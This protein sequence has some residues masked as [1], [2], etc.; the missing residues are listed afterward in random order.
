MWQVNKC[1]DYKIFLKFG[2]F[3]ATRIYNLV[4]LLFIN[5]I[6]LN[7]NPK[8]IKNYMKLYD[9]WWRKFSKSITFAWLK[10][11]VWQ[12]S[13]SGPTWPTTLWLIINITSCVSAEQSTLRPWPSILGPPPA[14]DKA[15]FPMVK[16]VGTVPPRPEIRPNFAGDRHRLKPRRRA[17]GTSNPGPNAVISCDFSV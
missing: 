14:L 3:R 17:A 16:L 15:W 7:K 13:E 11:N 1:A 10:F 4:I 8:N 5:L 6:F 9:H 2:G 12:I